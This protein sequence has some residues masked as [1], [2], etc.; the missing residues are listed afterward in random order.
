MWK[1]SGMDLLEGPLWSTMPLEAM[2][3]SVVHA[4][5]PDHSETQD[6]CGHMQSVQLPGYLVMSSGLAALGAMLM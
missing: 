5:T 1:G 3:V 2:L 6:P 4:S